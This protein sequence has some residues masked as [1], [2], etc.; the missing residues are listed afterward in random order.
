MKCR[1]ADQ[2]ARG[3]TRLTGKATLAADY[4]LPLGG[5]WLGTVSPGLT[6]R[7]VTGGL[8]QSFDLSPMLSAAPE[9]K[10]P[11]DACVLQ[12]SLQAMRWLNGGDADQEERDLRLE[13]PH[14]PE[15]L[16]R[17]RRLL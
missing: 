5:G 2:T 17:R 14:W 7:R 12:P 11:H 10:R 9:R 16:R 13:P 1:G 15:P 8:S 4:D 3:I 6:A